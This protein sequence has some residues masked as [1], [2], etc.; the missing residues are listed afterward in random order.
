MSAIEST[1]YRAGRVRDVSSSVLPSRI[2]SGV[3]ERARP[4]GLEIRESC[5]QG[6]DALHPSLVM[7]ARA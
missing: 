6:H 5:F 4:M 2:N 3:V 1:A 7:V